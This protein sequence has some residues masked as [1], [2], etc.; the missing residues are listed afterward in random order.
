MVGCAIA[1]SAL[2]HKYTPVMHRWPYLCGGWVSIADKS[3]GD[4]LVLLRQGHCLGALQ[5]NIVQYLN[6]VFYKKVTGSQLPSL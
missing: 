2:L 1:I 4:A 5:K 6:P 3:T